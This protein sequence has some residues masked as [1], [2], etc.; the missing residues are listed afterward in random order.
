MPSLPFSV[1]D[2]TSSSTDDSVQLNHLKRDLSG[3][4]VALYADSVVSRSGSI[5][6]KRANAV[7][8][9]W[10]STWEARHVHEYENENITFKGD[11][12]RFWWLAKLL[13]VA[14]VQS[15]VIN[16]DGELAIPSP[17]AADEK[18]KIA[19]QTKLVKWLARFRRE[20][21]EVDLPDEVN[22]LSELMK[23]R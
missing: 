17:N 16:Q 15:H 6:V 7:L 18:G 9:A 4:S 3:D 23:A 13:L 12:L 22:I 19:L 10:H 8:N 2:I 20:G 21:K 11:P 14:H 1:H 5:E